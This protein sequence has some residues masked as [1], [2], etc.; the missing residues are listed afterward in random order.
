V[1]STPDL[2]QS[3]LFLDDS[4]IE[5]TTFV[6]RQWH[7]PR[8][9]PDPVL[10]PEHPWERWCPVM[11]GTVLHWRGKFRMWYNCWSRETKPRVCYAESADGVAWEKPRLGLCAFDGSKDNNIILDPS[12]P[13]RLIDDITVMDDPDDRAWPLKALYWEGKAG[14]HKAARG[15]YAARSKD[16]IHWDRSPGLVV[17]GWGDRFNAVSVKLDG[18]YVIYGRRPGSWNQYGR[19][20]WRIE[21][22][23]LRRWSEGKLVLKRDPEDPIHMEYYSASVFPYESLT[24]GAIERMHMSPDRLDTEL[25]WSHDGGWK[26]ERAPKRPSFLGPST[27]DRR[28]D[29]T[30]VN[31]P[32]NPPIRSKG[33]LWFYYSGRSSAHACPYPMNHGAIGLALL[34]IDGF[35]SLRAAERRGLIVTKPMRWP[36]GDL[37]VNVDPRRDLESHPAFCH[38][39]ARVEVRDPSNR[40]LPGFTWEDCQPV[41]T[42]TVFDD[43]SCRAVAWKK[44]KSAHRL[45]GRR[46]RLAFQLRDAHLFSFR[47]RAAEPARRKP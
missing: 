43:G 42:N 46:I 17:P 34:R 7:Q 44:Q 19:C 29:D 22:R 32:T 1:N 10:R 23:D 39:E 13:E 37:C 25:I 8:K 28:W 40:P 9:F 21:S 47:A 24:L 27:G 6:S 36:G 4:W 33:R 2:T 20:V 38:G 41:T 18:K 3:Q 16:G 14:D 12:A 15:Y 31:L 5:E 35:A 30:W 26:W 11:F 45:A